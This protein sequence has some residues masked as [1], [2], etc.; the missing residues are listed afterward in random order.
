MYMLVGVSISNTVQGLQ[1]YENMHRNVFNG[2]IKGFTDLFYKKISL[3]FLR[4]HNDLIEMSL[5]NRQHYLATFISVS[6]MA[7]EA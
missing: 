5:M 7:L 2:Y 3:M 6:T 4:N 1:C